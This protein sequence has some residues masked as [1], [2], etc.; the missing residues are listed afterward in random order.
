MILNTFLNCEITLQKKFMVI[1][2]E[3][4]SNIGEDCDIIIVSFLW[5]FW[6]FLNKDGIWGFVRG[7]Y[8]GD[9]CDKEDD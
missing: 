8:C 1:L 9:N 3:K 2:D 7:G 4:L 6:I 5:V